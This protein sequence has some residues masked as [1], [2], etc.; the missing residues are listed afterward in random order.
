MNLM[1]NNLTKICEELDGI[2]NKPKN[3]QELI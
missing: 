1:D 2:S 3:I